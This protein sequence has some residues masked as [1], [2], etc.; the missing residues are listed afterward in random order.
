MTNTVSAAV[1]PAIGTAGSLS[2]VRSL[3]RQGV[4]VIAVSEKP[5]PPSFSSRYCDE[6]E[7]V[8]APAEDLTGYRDALLALASREDVGLVVPVR[9]P[10]VYVLAKHREA[11][12]E[13][14][15][16]P[17]P[18]VEQLRTVHDR[19]QL[20]DA[21]KRAGVTVPETR[22]LDEIDDWDRERIVKGR[23][24]IL[25]A[26]T[27]D[28]VEPGHI[29]SLPKTKFLDPGV[30]PDV[31]AIV[32]EM[33][34]VP[35][36]QTYVDGTEYCFRGLYRDGEPVVTSQ[37]KMV[38]GYKYARGPS[39]YHQ[40]VDIP[41]L[42]TAGRDLLSELEWDGIASVGFIRDDDGEFNL[43]EINPRIPASLPVDSHAGLDYPY[44]WWQLATG[45]SVGDHSED[46]RSGVASHLLRGELVHLHSVL[47][48]EYALAERP[49]GTK[50]AW[51]I[52]SSLVTQPQFDVLSLDDPAPFVREWL[53]V[54][55]GALRGT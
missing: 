1:V 53:N 32:E 12:A 40:A 49:S 44:Y 28:R 21:A 10:D 45:Q 41:D 14:I 16:T 7:R 8:P 33:G 30:R 15:A 26:D 9:E 5:S 54:A 37:K 55:R 2:T 43:L 11:F 47:R 29:G 25:T 48:E 23:Y 20:F 34:H 27:S 46:Y 24:A 22:L 3:G 39:V 38:R 31:D 51:N 50:T 42:E 6:T 4:T 17:W 52:A 19:L 35:I 18:A 13:E 36:T